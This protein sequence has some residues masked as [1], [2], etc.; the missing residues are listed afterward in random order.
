MVFVSGR[1]INSGR[2]ILPQ[3]SSLN[4]ALSAAGGPKVVRGKIEFVR[5]KKGGESERRVFN[6]SPNNMAR[7]SLYNTRMWIS[8]PRLIALAKR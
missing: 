3:G 6:Y 1:V 7:S 2:I 5:F 4:Q 8:A